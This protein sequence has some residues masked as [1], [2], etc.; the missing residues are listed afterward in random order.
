MRGRGKWLMVLV[1][2]ILFTLA[3]NAQ[4]APAERV[5]ASKVHGQ[6][7]KVVDVQVVDDTPHEVPCALGGA[8]EFVQLNGNQI[9]KL[10]T[11]SY[12]DGSYRLKL[13]LRFDGVTGVGLTSGEPYQARSSTKYIEQGFAPFP[14]DTFYR[15]KFDMSSLVSRTKLS[16]YERI[17]Q[18]IDAD[19][20]VT[21]SSTIEKTSC[22][23]KSG[24]I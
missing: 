15:F 19:G 22:T 18:S 2:L 20:N 8:G 21:F 5:S 9:V 11:T 7:F 17:T 10:K 6:T 23:Y 24:S 14:V 1:A 16:V 4:A 12:A 13:E 3:G